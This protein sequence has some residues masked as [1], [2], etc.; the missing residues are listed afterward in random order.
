MYSW[1]ATG[2]KA[3]PRSHCLCLLNNE[4]KGMS[5]HTLPIGELVLMPS[6][7]PTSFL[8]LLGQLVTPDIRNLFFQAGDQKC[9][10][11]TPGGLCD[12]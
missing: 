5:H 2:D 11:Q 1:L 9:E 3:G 7:A 10:V 4:I 6:L 12:L 8:W